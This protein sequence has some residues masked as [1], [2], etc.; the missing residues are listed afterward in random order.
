MRRGFTRGQSRSVFTWN[1]SAE[2]LRGV[3]VLSELSVADIDPKCCDY[4][5][6]FVLQ[7]KT[8]GTLA[9][10]AMTMKKL[11][12]SPH[13]GGQRASCFCNFTSSGK[14]TFPGVTTHGHSSQ[15]R[16]GKG[17][18]W[19]SL[20]LSDWSSDMS[21]LEVRTC[22]FMFG[23]ERHIAMQIPVS[24]IRRYHCTAHSQFHILS[25]FFFL[26]AWGR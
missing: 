14:T 16:D 19:K 24:R 18:S 11:V 5:P 12:W 25:F 17:S 2:R 13:G 7:W 23:V 4:E 3:W 15:S 9:S 6:L 21:G 20:G 26:R 22:A 10:K 8:R 1:R